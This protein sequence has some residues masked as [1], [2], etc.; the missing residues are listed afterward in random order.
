MGSFLITLRNCSKLFILLGKCTNQVTT[1]LLQTIKL[2]LIE[3]FDASIK[4]LE[5]GIHSDNQI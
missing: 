2:M 5:I 1:A 4:T 3:F